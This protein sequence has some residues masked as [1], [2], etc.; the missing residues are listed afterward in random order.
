MKPFAV[1]RL[2]SNDLMDFGYLDDRRLYR[3]MSGISG[4]AYR[5]SFRSVRRVTDDHM[6]DPD[7]PLYFADT[8]EDAE[9][10]AQQFARDRPGVQYIVVASQ[11]VWASPAA[12]PAKSI[13]TD[14][15]LIP[16]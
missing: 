5:Q 10:L 1:V 15:G 14:K 4:I 9:L 2:N 12:E 3:N 6:V 8:K 13:F 16:A 7:W 11:A